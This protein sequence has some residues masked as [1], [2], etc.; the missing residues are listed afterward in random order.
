MAGFS[1]GVGQRRGVTP[2]DAQCAQRWFRGGGC[3]PQTH[4]P[5][6]PCSPKHDRGLQS[7]QKRT[8]NKSAQRSTAQSRLVLPPSL[9]RAHDD[10]MGR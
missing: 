5:L 2:H 4:H 6:C 10:A 9:Q 8:K 3:R 7:P 1:R